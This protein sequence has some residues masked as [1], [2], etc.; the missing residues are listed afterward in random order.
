MPRARHITATVGLTIAFAGSAN[1]QPVHPALNRFV[2]AIVDQAAPLAVSVVVVRGDSIVH[3]AGYG[4]RDRARSLP[5]TPLSSFY[6]A[7]STKSFTA[8][9]AALLAA[10]GVVDLDAPISRYAPEFRLP[11]PMDA[12]RVTLRVLLSHRG[13]FESNPLSFRTA[14]TGDL[15]PDSLLPVLSR[16]ARPVDTVFA[17]TNT[18]F[19]VA[20]RVLERATGTSWQ[21]LVA[22]EVL[23][24]LGLRRTTAVP[25]AARGWE[26]VEGYGPGPGG[27]S[28]VAPKSDQTMHAAGGMLMSAEDAGTW[29]RAQL[30]RGRSSGRQRLPAAVIASTHRK[31]ATYSATEDDVRRFGYALG[32]QLGILDGDTLYHH[33]GNYPGAFAHVSFMPSRG[34][35]VAVFTNSDMPAFGAVSGTIARRAYDLLLDRN[36]DSIYAAFADSI[37]PRRNRMAAIFT[38]DF[39]RRAERP[40]APTRGWAAFAGQYEA[41]DMGTLRIVALGDSGAELRYGQ[42]RERLE[43][44]SGDTLRVDVPPG[45]NGRPVPVVFGPD[46][47]ASSVTVAG[48]AFV[49]AS[50]GR[51]PAGTT[52]RQLDSTWARMYVT[53]DTMTAHRL[54]SDDLVWTSMDGRQKDKRGELGDVRP[55][56]GLVMEYFRTADVDARIYDNA[57]VVTGLA[58]WKYTMNLTPTEI[59]RRYTTVYVRGGPLG[60]RIVAVQIGRAP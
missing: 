60:W 54:Y 2:R 1:A 34:I 46:G 23:N 19:I 9:T 48:T 24:P 58:E 56:A 17:Y 42:I 57:A 41:G 33:L 29:L 32:W 49:R 27:F 38:N 47:R 15:P 43:V 11:A 18:A 50:A 51:S 55:T 37:G 26:L 39:R 5:V 14:Y 36:R 45:R 12:E 3:L 44:L 6:I 22:R 8:L 31:L 13:G 35:G 53:H 21:E 20:A 59:R 16:S 10:R 25:T 30:T 4:M 52:I 7:S 28:V 40:R